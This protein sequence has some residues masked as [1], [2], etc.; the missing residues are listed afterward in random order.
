MPKRKLGPK[1]KKATGRAPARIE[2]P[3]WLSEGPTGAAPRPPVR[4]RTGILPFTSLTWEDFERLCVR[5][6]GR[7]AD[8]EAAWAYGKSGHAQH[9]IDVLVRVPDG[10]FYVWQSKRHESISKAKIEAAVQ[11][12]LSRKW[13]K[14]ATRFVLAVG[15]EFSSPAVVEAIEAARDKLHARNIEFEPLDATELTQRLRNDAELIDDFFGRP[16]AEAI[17]PPEAVEQLS[18]RLSRFDAADLRNGL[19]SCYNSWISTVDPGLPIVGVDAQGRTRASIPLTNR[20]IRPDLLV[21]SSETEDSGT[22]ANDLAAKRQ[23]SLSAKTGSRE[24]DPRSSN[25]SRPRAFLRERRTELDDYLGDHTRSLILGDAG[26]GKSTLLRFLALDILSG[27]P[28]LRAT[29]ERYKNLI[30]VWLPFALWVRM[31]VDRHAPAPI[32]DAVAEYLRAQGGPELAENMRR[33]VLGKRIVLLVDGIDEAADPA[34]AQTLLAVLTTFVDRAGISVIATSRPHGARSLTGLGDA[35]ERATLAPLSDDQRHAL[36][37]LWFGL[38]ERFE[39]ENVTDAQIRARSRRK[40]D[41]FISALQ[42]NIGINRLSQTP[43]FLLAFI[44]LHSRG[45]DLPRSRFA[46]SKEIVDQLMEHQP[47][48]RAVSALSTTSSQAEPRLR[49]RLISDFAFALQSGDLRGAIPDAASEDEAIARG[50][51][52][53]LQRQNTGNQ[54]AAEASA[55]AIFSF[56]EERAGLL[57]NKAP[58]NI[59]FL[60]LSLQE[61]LAA[62]YLM[63]LSASDKLAFVGANAGALRWREPILYL[64]A[65]TS[66]EA[67]AGQLVEAIEKAEPKNFAEQA[68]RDALLADAVFADF[69]HDLSVVR[70]VAQGCLAEAETTAWGERQRHLLTAA[71]DGLFSESVHSLCKTKLA[72]W[73]P[74]RHGYDRGAAIDAIGGWDAPSRAAAIPALLRCLRS[75]NEHIWRKA[76]Q[77][78]PLVADRSADIKGRLFRLAKAA[79]SVQTAQAALFSV[80]F[81]W[82]QDA[83]V[84]D[85]ARELRANSHD[86]L[87]LDAIRIR[88]HRGETDSED[89]ERFFAIAYEKERYSDSFF[90]PDLAEHFALHH[91]DAFTQ[92]LESAVGAQMGERIHRIKPLVGALFLCDSN[93]ATAQRELSGMLAQDWVLAD[94]F[95]R[96]N[97]P[98]DRVTWTPKLVAKIE[99]QIANKKRYG[100]HDLYWISKTLRLPH[101]KQRFL[102]GLRQGEHLGFW[103]SRGLA[104]IWGKDDPEV[105]DL[106]SSMLDADPKHLSEVA[107]ELPLII[108]D[109]A[110]CRAALLRGMRADVPRYDFLLKGCKNLGVTA[111]DEEMVQAALAAGERK[112]APLYRDMWCANII[113]TFPTHPRVRTIAEHELLRR[114]GSLG[115]VAFGYPNDPDMCRRVLNVLCPLDE[116]ARMTLVRALETAAPANAVAH[117]LLVNARE[118]TDG[119]VCAESIMGGVEATLARG[120]LPE[121]DLRWLVEE[122]DTVGPEY[123]KRRAAAVVGLLLAGNIERF[124]TAKERGNKPLD[125][126]INPDLTKEDLYL[127]RLLPR[128]TELSQA[129]GGDPEILSRFEITPERTLRSLHAGIPHVHRLFGLLMDKVPSAQHLH[130]NDLI[131]ALAEFSPNGHQMRE[132]LDAMLRS[133]FHGRT[134]GD[135]TAILHAGQIFADYF[136]DDRELRNLAI[137][138][139]HAYPASPMAAGVLAELLLRENNRALADSVFEGVRQQRYDLGTNFKLMAVFASNEVII[140][141]ITDLLKT[142]IEPQSWAVPYW[143]PALVRRIATDPTLQAAMRMA[144]TQAKTASVKVTLSALLGRAMSQA[145]DLRQYAIEELGKLEKDPMPVIGLDL[146]T[147]AHRLLFQVLTELAL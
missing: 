45:Q 92:K 39:A 38:L 52:L 6:A 115:A 127:R 103:Y 141:T 147:N 50:S 120:P 139:F 104:E 144:L 21:R 102:E 88:A 8:V 60:H 26:S 67:D 53:I 43:L 18:Q 146:T 68:A 107:G 83:D 94:L 105:Q 51:R 119:L 75:E 70:R 82:T 74:D 14:Q 133:P 48:R 13:A 5:L 79:P 55:R 86:G 30:P 140:E 117:E 95:T 89:L 135:L 131:A 113:A 134:I 81:G 96:G 56:T 41:A 142:D 37:S 128:W 29:Q 57:V 138:T 110:A 12:F 98:V 42:G 124:V 69:S 99:A 25:V 32:E 24:P 137:Q 80:G 125:V 121:D 130:K 72:E 112:R 17:C 78:L 28:V 122:L 9:G 65:M 90:A 123:E 73:V 100:D 23:P 3:S 4:S 59:G 126:P 101:L 7:G 63:Q 145:D 118:D 62:R 54:D 11:Y 33:A 77:V 108:D 49:D 109:H 111:G 85:M 116:S 19:Q 87:C 2:N 129:L 58:G 132:L 40:A 20:Y 114:D 35:W 64:L 44:S 93:N 27:Q 143:V 34:V 10:A 91:H 66:N 106:F 136:R 22:S 71:V 1:K 97:F 31:S 84:G 16:W 61:Y 15:C 76:A 36:A 46:A 47:N